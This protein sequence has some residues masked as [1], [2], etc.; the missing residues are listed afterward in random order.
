MKIPIRKSPFPISGRLQSDKLLWRIAIHNIKKKRDSMFVLEP[1]AML[2]PL[3]S[4]GN[5]ALAH[6]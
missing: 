2:I 3:E 4:P 1:C 5:D 6:P